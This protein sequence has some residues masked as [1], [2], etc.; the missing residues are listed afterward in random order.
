MKYAMVT[1]CDH[2][3]GLYLARE[4]LKRGYKTIACCLR[5]PPVELEEAHPGSVHLLRLDIG[6]DESVK[7]TRDSVARIVP[8]LDLLIN[9]AGILGEMESGPDDPLDFEMMQRVINVN[10]LGTLR[11]TAAMLPLLRLGKEKTIVNI[12]SEAGSI[13]DCERTGWFGYCMSKAANNMQGALI[14]NSFRLEGG[15]VYQIH[16]GHM[17]TY[18]RG[19]LDTTAQITPS[20]SA[21]GILKTV[22]DGNYPISKRPMYLDYTGEE[23]HW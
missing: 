14:H 6:S 4:L 11:V 17:A 18:M 23:L 19:H 16:P 20:E 3:L 15:R 7:R 13:Q 12:S 1:G 21:A 5:E 8:K 22:L 9:N 2:G 10:A